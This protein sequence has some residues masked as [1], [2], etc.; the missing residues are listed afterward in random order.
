[1]A[2]W[3]IT[4]ASFDIDRVAEGDTLECPYTGSEVSITLPA[5][6]YTITARGA[7][8]RCGYRTNQTGP[9]GSYSAVGEGGTT[10]G[11]YDIEDNTKIYINVGGLGATA[12]NSS[13]TNAGGYN[14]GGS[15]NYYGGTGGGATHIALTSGLLSTLSSK[16]AQIILV[17]GGG[18]GTTWYSNSYYG[19]GGSGGGTAGDAGKNKTAAN[20]AYAGQGG[21]QTA[22]GAAGTNTTR[23]GDAGTFGQGG[24][25]LNCTSSYASSAGGGGYYG[26]GAGS[27][28]EAGGGGGSGYINTSL[29]TDATTTRGSTTQNPAAGEVTI[30]VVEF[31]N[32]T[33]YNLELDLAGANYTSDTQNGTIEVREGSSLEFSFLPLDP[34]DPV[35]VYKNNVE[36]TDQLRTVQTTSAIS[37]TPQVSGAAYGFS[38]SGNY[39]VSQNKG[40]AKSAAVARVNITCVERTTVTFNVI[41]Y[42]EEGYDFGVLGLLDEPLATTYNTDN[43]GYWNGF[44]SS[45]NTSA[46]QTVT[47][48]VPIGEHFID[49]KY[50]KDDATDQ[51][52][53]NFQF[54][55]SMSPAPGDIRTQYFLNTGAIM[56]DTQIKIICG[57]V[58]KNFNILATAEHANVDPRSETI[59]KGSNYELHFIPTDTEDYR[60]IATYDN[61]VDVTSSVVAPH[62]LPT[63]TWEVTEF[64]GASYGFALT[65]GYY[66]SQNTATN[67][68]AL[69]KVVF[70]TPVAARVTITYQNTGYSTYNFSMISELDTDLRTDYATDTSGMAMN[71]SSNFHSTDTILTYDV[72]AGEHYITCKHKITNNNKKGNLKF[73]VAIEAVESLEIPYYT[74]SLTNIQAVHNILIVSEKIPIYCLNISNGPMG[75]LDSTGA[76]Y[77]KEGSSFTINCTPDI[78]YAVDKI[79]VNSESVAFSGNSYTVTNIQSDMNLYVLFSSGNTTFS[80]KENG[81]WVQVIQAYKKVD[82]RWVAQEFALVGD[83]NTK[84]VRKN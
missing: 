75:S 46:V 56:T 63:P 53:D 60:Y 25:N 79:F 41:N 28:Q 34:E 84:Y 45:R 3:D 72:P 31:Y 6:K 18:G 30:V 51:Y 7:D 44:A 40:V 20:T 2:T 38:L 33:K 32:V 74:Y 68:A 29:L 39:Y 66:Q 23:K 76:Q 57:D 24:S 15:T 64:P 14:G 69:C 21:T 59:Y 61:N 80:I 50:I 16:I 36:I 71:G 70:N 12:A 42:A 49:V 81:S 65:S 47:Y 73:K 48:T 37:V 77:L 54:N 10:T 82:G 67:S 8:G 11:T 19:I 58:S 52:N 43:S 83:P 22:G 1:M 9:S 4:S 55:V 27:N 78:N 35:T 5:G 13:S 62:T 26:G 17:A